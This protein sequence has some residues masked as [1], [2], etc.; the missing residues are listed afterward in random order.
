MDNT[1][2]LFPVAWAAQRSGL[3]YTPVNWHLKGEE[4]AYVI[5]D[6]GAKLLFADAENGT[7][8]A[9]IAKSGNVIVVV[10]GE[11][12][13]A[14]ERLEDA[15]ESMPDHPVADETEGADMIYTSGT[16]GRPKGGMRPLPGL[17]P[18]GENRKLSYYR[19][20]SDSTIQASI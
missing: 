11:D 7:A 4:I 10:H 15:I 18:A 19:L 20:N 6:S 16:T 14:C 9:E 2:E 5:A 17:H 12:V 3:Y 13:P 8:A 1:A